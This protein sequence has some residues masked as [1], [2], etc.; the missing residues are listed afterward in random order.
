MTLY[1][2]ITIL[3]LQFSASTIHTRS[4]LTSLLV[5]HPHTVEVEV[6][7]ENQKIALLKEIRTADLLILSTSIAL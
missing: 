5:Y 3:Q 4:E 2:T 1:S 6:K 7:T